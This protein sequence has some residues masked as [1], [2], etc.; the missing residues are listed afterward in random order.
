[1]L[2]GDALQETRSAPGVV[3]GIKPGA[4]GG[5]VLGLDFSALAELLSRRFPL[6]GLPLSR[7]NHPKP[8]K[9]DGTVKT[10][11]IDETDETTKSTKPAKIDGTIKTVQVD[12]TVQTDEIPRGGEGSERMTKTTL[13]LGPRVYN[14]HIVVH[15]DDT[16]PASCVSGY[17]SGI[18]RVLY[19]R[20]PVC[21]GSGYI[22]F[23]H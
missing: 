20:L 5:L 23:M 12:E 22:L 17:N 21:G 11:E 1:M 2:T 6:R 10:I 4:S 18:L 8:T 3:L 19:Y 13:S 7:I 16:F 14:M 15:F 9:I